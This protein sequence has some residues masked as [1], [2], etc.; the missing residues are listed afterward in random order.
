[1]KIYRFSNPSVFGPGQC[2]IVLSDNN[3]NALRAFVERYCPECSIVNLSKDFNRD[4]VTI[5]EVSAEPLFYGK[6]IFS[7]VFAIEIS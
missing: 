3:M 5:M 2:V 7:K 4:D 1:M 6:V